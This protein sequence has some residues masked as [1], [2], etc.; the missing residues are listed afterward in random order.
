MCFLAVAFSSAA[1]L[2][3]GAPVAFALG[4]AWDGVGQGRSRPGRTLFNVMAV[5]SSVRSH[6]NVAQR[7]GAAPR[8]NVSSK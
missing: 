4:L 7:P 6:E 8:R 1:A 3:A 2:H 5:G